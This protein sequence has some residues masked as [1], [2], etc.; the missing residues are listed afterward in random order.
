MWKAR[1]TNG[2]GTSVD[3]AMTTANYFLEKIKIREGFRLVLPEYD[4][5][6]ICFWYVIKNCSIFVMGI[7][8]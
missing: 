3:I 6:N 7:V 8:D 4:G 5:N 2:L 1:G